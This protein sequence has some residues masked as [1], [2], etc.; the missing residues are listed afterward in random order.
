MPSGVAVVDVVGWTWCGAALLS[1]GQVVESA[2][3]P[4][5]E[6][7]EIV[8]RL[9]R[10]VSGIP[11]SEAETLSIQHGVGI[12]RVPCPP[13]EIG[14]EVP[15]TWAKM[16]DAAAIQLTD[17]S[18]LASALEPDRSLEHRLA[19]YDEIHESLEILKH[20]LVEWIG[21]LLPA[22]DVQ[23]DRNRIISA[24]Q[25]EGNLASIATSLDLQP[26][27][28]P[29]KNL[30]I[31]SVKSL[32]TMIGQMEMTSGAILDEVRSLAKERAPSLSN[33]IGPVL[34]ARLIV[35][36][37][38]LDRLSRLSSGAIQMLGAERSFFLALEHGRPTPKHGSILFSHPW[39]HASPKGVRGRVA[40]MLS[41]RLSIAARLDAFGGTPWGEDE[42]TMISSKVDAIRA[43]GGHSQ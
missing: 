15:E 29:D 33:V 2:V 25:V 40:R 20:R 8:E 34:S 13:F 6:T 18:L 7:S 30:V 41:G 3:P 23:M 12:E 22:L 26:K 38:G 14:I 24:V 17:N 37:H 31:E 21:Y 5:L 36:A 35:A 4:N 27:D 42:V 9:E 32:S 10:L 19:A 16:R 28:V 1:E 43:A 39:V 11:S